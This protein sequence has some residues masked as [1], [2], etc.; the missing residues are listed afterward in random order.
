[1]TSC[2]LVASYRRCSASAVAFDDLY[3]MRQSGRIITC[4]PIILQRR[5]SLTGAISSGVRLSCV[6]NKAF[7]SPKTSQRQTSWLTPSYMSQF[8]DLP[9]VGLTGKSSRSSK[10]KIINSARRDEWTPILHQ[11]WENHLHMQVY[12]TD[13]S[14]IVDRLNCKLCI[15]WHRM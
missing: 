10:I 7:V 4:R 9:R 13:F 3:R 12:S 1:M 5:W 8:H 11:L 6:V 14:F 2:R 15:V